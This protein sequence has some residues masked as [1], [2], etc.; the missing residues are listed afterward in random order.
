MECLYWPLKQRNRDEERKCNKVQLSPGGCRK[1]ERTAP[2]G[3][4]VENGTRRNDRKS[5]EDGPPASQAHVNTE[6]PDRQCL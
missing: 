4:T 1:S 5:S 6:F 3:Y 2:V